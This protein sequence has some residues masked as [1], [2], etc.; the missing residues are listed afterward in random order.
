MVC[1]HFFQKKLYNPKDINTK[2]SLSCYNSELYQEVLIM[3]VMILARH[4]FYGLSMLDKFKGLGWKKKSM[5]LLWLESWFRLYVWF[6]SE[7]IPLWFRQWYWLYFYWQ[8]FESGWN[9]LLYVDIIFSIIISIAKR[10]ETTCA[11]TL[12]VA[13]LTSC[14][15]QPFLIS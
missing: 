12:A 13:V 8:Y 4:L 1:K 7:R 14:D 10:S 15:Q 2:S 3:T 5:F 11:Y 9:Y 6:S